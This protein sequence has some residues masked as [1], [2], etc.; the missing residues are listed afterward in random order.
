V[1]S[2]IRKKPYRTDTLSRARRSLRTLRGLYRSLKGVKNHRVAMLV[3]SNI[4]VISLITRRRHLNGF[5]NVDRSII[6]GRIEATTESRCL[7]LRACIYLL[8]REQV[9]AAA[10]DF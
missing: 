10:I 1:I 9:M 3:V 6:I 2:L 8:L 4:V 7:I 5:N